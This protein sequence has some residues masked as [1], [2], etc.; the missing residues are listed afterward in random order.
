MSSERSFL[1]KP[2]FGYDFVVGVT[3][4]SINATLLTYLS[5][6]SQ[7]LIEMCYVADEDGNAKEIELSK[8][9]ERTG[10]VNPFTAPIPDTGFLDDPNFQKLLEGEFLMGFRAR[11]G[12]PAV[13]DP[14]K[15]PDMVVLQG[16]AASVKFRLMCSEF[17]VATV[18]PALNP[19]KTKWVRTSQ[20]P[21]S[22]WLFG[23]SVDLRMSDVPD[24]A[25]GKLPKDVQKVIKNM[26]GTAF[27]IQQLLLDL[28][29]AR[30]ASTLDIEGIPPESE[31]YAKLSGYF[32]KKYFEN[33]QKKGDPILGCTVVPRTAPKSTLTLTDFDFAVTPFIDPATQAPKNPATDE[34]KQLNTLNYLCAADG[35]KLP[36]AGRL[37]WNW[38][39][40]AQAS[41]HHGCVSINRDRIVD[42][43][44]KLLADTAQRHC[45]RPKVY[46]RHFDGNITRLHVDVELHDNQPPQVINRPAGGTKTDPEGLALEYSYRGWSDDDDQAG[47]AELETRYRMTVCLKGTSIVVQQNIWVWYYAKAGAG[48]NHDVVVDDLLTCK[49]PIGIANDGK[50][51]VGNAE[52]TLDKRARPNSRS[53]IVN[54]FTNINKITDEIIRQVHALDSIELKQIPLSSMQNYVFPGGKAFV[55]KNAK[56]S[57]FGDLVSDITY[58]DPGVIVDED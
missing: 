48:D 40:P 5:N 49:Y 37:A 45:M 3:Q 25:Y 53:G 4:A 42:W 22:P 15:L 38:V 30:L 55:F 14:S 18:I 44:D 6:V 52:T 31:I 54:A 24:T 2:E 21:T 34:E 23:T 36:R 33:A 7:P 1:S 11:M 41:S 35:H 43:L 27:T 39:S 57:D 12:V 47:K 10:G 58:A 28:T 32:V 16:D 17:T 13:P 26:S 20:D 50:L 9:L 19:K 51:V 56:F 8:L 29:N 46:A